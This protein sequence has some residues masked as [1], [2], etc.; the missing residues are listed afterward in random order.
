MAYI[1]TKTFTEVVQT[2]PNVCWWST[3]CAL[4]YLLQAVRIVTYIHLHINN[5]LINIYSQDLRLDGYV[6][7]MLWQGHRRYSF[8]YLFYLHD[9]T[10]RL[11]YL[12]GRRPQKSQTTVLAIL[13]KIEEARGKL[14]S[15]YFRIAYN[16]LKWITVSNG[17]ISLLC[18]QLLKVIFCW[19][20][21]LDIS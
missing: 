19:N 18:R 1:R 12:I 6:C 13:F 20:V 7:V 8:F 16:F 15:F 4:G 21:V 10:D 14:N 3:S 2:P 5:K 17:V 11:V 9:I